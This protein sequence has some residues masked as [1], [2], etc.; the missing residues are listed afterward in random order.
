MSVDIDA[1]SGIVGKCLT[2]EVMEDGIRKIPA[3]KLVRLAAQV[4]IAEAFQE[5]AYLLHEYSGIQ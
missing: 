1:I 4:A 5:L 3:E 2:L